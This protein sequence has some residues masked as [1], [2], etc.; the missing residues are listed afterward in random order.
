MSKKILKTNNKAQSVPTGLGRQLKDDE[1]LDNEFDKIFHPEKFDVAQLNPSDTGYVD[2]ERKKYYRSSS[3]DDGA[4]YSI[5]GLELDN[6]RADSGKRSFARDE[7]LQDQG[8]RNVAS[9]GNFPETWDLET[10]HSKHEFAHNNPIMT[11]IKTGHHHGKHRKTSDQKHRKP[12]SQVHHLSGIQEGERE[13]EDDSKE[14]SQEPLEDE[15]KESLPWK[16]ARD[17]DPI[18]SDDKPASQEPVLS[19]RD[20]GDKSDTPE[21]ASEEV[22]TKRGGVMFTIGTEEEK[23]DGHDEDYKK[24][25]R[26]IS[27]TRKKDRHHEEV[28][29]EMRR[30]P[31]SELQISE[32]VLHEDDDENLKEGD[33]EEIAGHRFEKSKGLT[34]HKISHGHHKP[35]MVRVG[36][37][38]AKNIGQDMKM[39]K[40]MG[41]GFRTELDHSPHE[42]FVEMDELEGE[43]WVERSRW[44]KYEEDLEAEV[45]RWGKPHVASLTF[46]SLINLRLCMESGTLMLDITARDLPELVHRVVEDL[47]EKGII[48]E[49]QKAKVLRV[50][51]Y[52]HK[53]VHPHANTFKFG[54]KRSMSQ[55]SIQGLLDDGKKGSKSND[56]MAKQDANSNYNNMENGFPPSKDEDHLV[57]DMN[58]AHSGLKRSSTNGS[59]KRNDSFDNIVKAR[60]QDIRACMEDGT[61]GAIVLVGTLD[62]IDKPIVAF[63]RLGEAIVMPNTIEVSLPVRFIFI[64][65]TPAENLNMDPHEIGRSF[66]TLMSN[67]AFHN[68]AYRVEEK[69]ELL[70]AINEFLDDSV[71][72]P[73]GDWDR[74]H[75]LPINEIMEMRQRRKT[76]KGLKDADGGG[77]GGEGPGGG[78]DGDDKDKGP[79][80]RN[81]LKRTSTPFGGLIDD[82]KN[83]YPQFLSDIKDGLNSQCLAA[84]IFIYFAALSGAIAFGGIMGEKT[85]NDIGVSETLVVTCA[86]GIIFALFS[87]CPLIIIGTTGPVLLYD[88]ALYDFCKKNM[89]NQFLYWRV[90][91]GIWTFIIS[92][93]VAGFQG[94]TL[95]RFFTKFTKDIFAG[96]VSLLFIFEALRKLVIIFNNHP[97]I[98]VPGYCA[99]HT[100]CSNMTEENFINN[101]TEEKLCLDTSS[102]DVPPE[103]NTALLSMI[104]MF[105]TFFI[106][107]FLR[108]FRN[109]QFLGRNARRALGDF[110]VPIAIVIMVLVDYSTGDTFT[111]KLNV[112]EGISVTNPAVRGW[113]INPLGK[114]EE[115]LPVYAMFAAVLPAVLLYLL[116]FMETHI[117]EL[118]MMEKTKEEK[119]AGLHLDIV[120]LSLMNMICAIF[121]GPWICAATVRSVSHVSALTVMSTTHVPGEAPKVIGVRD[122]RVTATMVSV[123]I[124]V[125]IVLAPILKMVPFA[126]LFGVFLYMGVSGMNGV[127]FFDRLAL[128]FMPIKHHPSV[129]YVKKV[130]TWRMVMFTMF[131]GLGLVIL[132]IVK[133]TPAALAFPFFVVAMIPY[134]LSLKWVYTSCELE[135]LDGAQAGKTYEDTTE[136]LDFFETANECPITPNTEMPLHRSLMGM[137]KL[138]TLMGGKGKSK[139]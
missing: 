11:K 84:T 74:K 112:P 106:A 110:G 45:G 138:P 121:G 108:I 118:I 91:V 101:S 78:G 27:G 127:Q 32:N 31:G 83:R 73:P 63:V 49:D 37:D 21:D 102:D 6:P 90:W 29:L 16:V 124:G 100:P 9:D 26:K 94:S 13:N 103:P 111:E 68:V 133:S 95:V 7:P 99:R 132:W 2:E 115:P 120:M 114:S 18:L 139:S 20:Y 12:S 75:I 105:G 41:Y 125:S 135:A 96:L 60:K 89:P 56:D 23:E 81:P 48:E 67:P 42:L 113:F 71:V 33:L 117:C 59:F 66:S 86:C 50:L 14:R 72:L 28:S 92:L 57:L 5:P 52:R 80:K 131:Q 44:I 79:P 30:R 76:R 1:T 43:E 53:H 104:L 136:E 93:A 34:K 40:S 51:L 85:N 36:A 8:L 69:Q 97:L 134:R 4:S 107:Y 128:C 3:A 77:D 10:E 35:H 24:N 54:L 116:L 98:A 19:E 58:G 17:D 64:L 62:D 137:V 126:V 46:H 109:S 82:I 119:G 55:R 87:G 38:E 25:H 123:L 88:E 61:E 39:M 15:P 70:H 129:S 22:H 122:Q 65:L 47:S 130:K